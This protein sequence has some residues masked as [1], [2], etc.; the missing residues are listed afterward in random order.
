MTL[1]LDSIG[2]FEITYNSETSKPPGEYSWYAI[3]N[4]T[5]YK[6]NVVTF[7]IIVK[8]TIAMTPMSGPP[9]TT[10][11]EWG[12]GFTP[13][14]TATLYFPKYDGTHNGS[15]TLTLDSIGH[16]EITYNS[17]TNKPIGKYSWYAI[18]NTTGK[19]SNTVTFTITK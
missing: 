7:T 6:S 19:K 9:G 8:P 16:F 14:G 17:E 3:D 5:G 13:N 15:M 12:T 1:T 11:V 4:A 2:H 10:F 18:D